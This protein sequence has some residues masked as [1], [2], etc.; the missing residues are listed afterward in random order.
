MSRLREKTSLD[1][2]G[3]QGGGKKAYLTGIKK[4][5]EG[6][7]ANQAGGVDVNW[8]SN[9]WSWYGGGGL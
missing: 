2:G 4:R 7:N 6:R 1:K 3:G 8:D 5:I 9:C